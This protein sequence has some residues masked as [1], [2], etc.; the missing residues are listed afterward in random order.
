[1]A[2]SHPGLK[3][4]YN[5]LNRLYFDGDLPDIEIVWEPTGDAIALSH[6]C[7]EGIEI[8][9]LTF[10]PALKGYNKIIKTYMMHEMI[11]IKYPK[12][13]H[14]ERFKAELDRLWDKGAYYKL[15]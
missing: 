10:D 12:I 9:R 8:A 15:L 13:G 11:H 1:M 6:Y 14:G 7:S 4:I 3:R 5:R 2:G